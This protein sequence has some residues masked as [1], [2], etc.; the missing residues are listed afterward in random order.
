MKL[1]Y[2]GPRE[3]SNAF[4]ALR[5]ARHSACTACITC[6]GLFPPPGIVVVSSDDDSPQSPLDELGQ[7]GSDDEDLSS[8]YLS[9]CACGHSVIEHGADQELIGLEEFQRRSRVALRLDELL[10]VRTS[11]LCRK[12]LINYLAFY[13]Y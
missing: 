7:Y 9:T 6:D 11:F 10:Q 1:A 13:R 3:V 8:N 2:P 5:I 4:S 12:A